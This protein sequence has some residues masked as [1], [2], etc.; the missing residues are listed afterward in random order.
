MHLYIPSVYQFETGYKIQ[1]LYMQSLRLLWI[2]FFSY[3]IFVSYLFT[4]TSGGIS[5]FYIYFCA[6]RS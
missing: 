3:D 2:I 4:I 1:A 6:I 5:N